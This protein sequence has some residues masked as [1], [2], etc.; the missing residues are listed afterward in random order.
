MVCVAARALGRKVKWIEDRSE[1]LTAAYRARLALDDA[2]NVLALHAELRGDAGTF[3][4]SGTGGTGPFQVAGMMIEGLYRFRSAGATVSAWYTNAP[5]T[6]ACRGCGMQEGTW[7]RE[8]L[9]DEA[10]RG[11]RVGPRRTPA[12]EHAHGGRVTP[13]D[14]HR[15][16]LRRR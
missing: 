2:G 14:A 4:A 1:A 11:N 15:H 10:A 12:A 13:C 6:T 3:C 9:V 8:R 16:P 7:M 5:P